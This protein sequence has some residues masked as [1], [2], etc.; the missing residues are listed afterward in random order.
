MHACMLTT[1]CARSVHAQHHWLITHT[2]LSSRMPV[3]ARPTWPVA[4][5][6]RAALK[7][8]QR[9]GVPQ[10]RRL[11]RLG[12]HGKLGGV[13]RQRCGAVGLGAQPGGGNGARLLHGL[14]ARLVAGAANGRRELADVGA[15]CIAARG[16]R[17][18]SVTTGAQPAG[19]ICMQSS[20]SKASAAGRTV[21]LAE[22]PARMWSPSVSNR[23]RHSSVG[24][25]GS[26]CA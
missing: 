19:C 18:M 17:V 16:G 22:K 12:R 4:A 23:L 26:T 24:S 7:G 10:R 9:G 20:I 11:Q 3:G 25:S 8:R 6:C 2:C 13:G 21:V 15:L 5:G 14:T 1:G